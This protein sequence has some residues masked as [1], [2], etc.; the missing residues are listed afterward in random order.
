MDYEFF[1]EFKKLSIKCP[2]EH[3]KSKN[4]PVYRWVFDDINDE[5]NFKPRWYILPDVELEKVE[6]ITDAMKRDTQKCSMLALSM[7]VSEDD[8]KNRFEYFLDTHGKKSYK[9][10]GTNISKGEI[11][12]NDGVNE[13]PNN[14]GHFNHHPVRGC[15]YEKRFIIISKL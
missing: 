3:Y 8:A 2:P 15:E 4:M 7:F 5:N 6:Q 11:T 10:F 12:E 13:A 1:E 9:R 14:A